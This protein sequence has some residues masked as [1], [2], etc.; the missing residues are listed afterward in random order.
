MSGIITDNLGRSSGLVKAASGG[1]AWNFISDTTVSAAS[2]VTVN[3]GIDSTYDLYM[4][5]MQMTSDTDSQDWT[6]QFEA[7]GAV[8]TDSDYRYDIVNGYT[9]S[10]SLQHTKDND[11]TSIKINADG[12]EG[13][14]NNPLDI[15]LYLHHPADTAW[16]TQCQF[17]GCCIQHDNSYQNW[18]GSGIYEPT[19]AVTGIR[20]GLDSGDFRDGNIRLYGLAKS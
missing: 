1:G 8:D 3:S 10:T 19:A 6:M 13:D 5:V 11:S 20:L 18:K 17:Y 16:Y 14:D 2:T 12:S 7:D 15:I 9:T 4:F